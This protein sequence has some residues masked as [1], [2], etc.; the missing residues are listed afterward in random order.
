MDKMNFIQS[1]GIYRSELPSIRSELENSIQR[2][3][4]DSNT[5]QKSRL[6]HIFNLIEQIVND[7]S[8]STISI[9]YSPKLSDVDTNTLVKFGELVAA[10]RH[11]LSQD[12]ELTLSKI[13]IKYI[14]SIS[15]DGNIENDRMVD[16]S[17]PDVPRG[18][19]ISATLSSKK[20]TLED[21]ISWAVTND[22]ENAKKLNVLAQSLSKTKPIYSN[23]S[24]SEYISNLI[25]K[26]QEWADRTDK[27]IQGFIERLKIEPIG[28]LHLERIET[29]PA[30]MERGELAYSV[31]LAPKEVITISHKEWS[32]QNSEF[33]DFVSD[34]FEGF[35]EQGVAE[36]NDI[37]RSV[38]SQSAHA[39][40]LNVNASAEGFGCSISTNFEL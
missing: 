14:A 23:L 1:L 7:T 5:N 9:R 27:T 12:V 11:K 10:H 16:T 36:K 4:I 30:G 19:I 26:T 21:T 8:P 3:R 2:E 33:T 38:D 31:P 15:L 34:Y 25:P 29:T 35:S 40:A 6:M 28:R 39:S 22:K 24:E 13:R 37:A 20:Y 32:T 17:N 18:N